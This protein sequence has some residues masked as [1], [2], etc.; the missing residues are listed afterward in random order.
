MRGNTTNDVLCFLNLGAISTGVV[1]G[2]ENLDLGLCCGSR[3]KRYFRPTDGDGNLP[4]EGGDIGIGLREIP[5][6]RS[7]SNPGMQGV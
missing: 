2:W 1:A 7:C 3:S 4:R 5:G 6:C